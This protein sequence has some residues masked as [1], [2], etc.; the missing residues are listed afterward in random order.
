LILKKQAKVLGD[1]HTREDN[2]QINFKETGYSIGK[3][4]Y[5]GR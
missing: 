5:K 2:I 4:A 1:M 3:H